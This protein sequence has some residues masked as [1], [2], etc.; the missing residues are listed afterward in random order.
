[1][2]KL[3]PER[4][5]ILLDVTQLKGPKQ[6]LDLSNLTVVLRFFASVLYCFKWL[7]S[8]TFHVS[9]PEKVRDGRNLRDCLVC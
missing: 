3:R 8:K 7:Q 1:M 4:L 6:D 9:G 5:C 2:R